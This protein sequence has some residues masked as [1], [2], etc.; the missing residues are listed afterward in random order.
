MDSIAYKRQTEDVESL[1]LVHTVILYF[2]EFVSFI[3]MYTY[4]IVA[5]LFFL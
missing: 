1:S 5:I 2:Y 3:S 4:I